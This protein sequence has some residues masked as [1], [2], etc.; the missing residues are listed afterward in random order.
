MMKLTTMIATATGIAA[1][2][3]AAFAQ[4]GSSGLPPT[5]SDFDACN[6][7]AQLIRGGSASPATSPQTGSS[8]GSSRTLPSSIATGPTG[9][10]PPG[11]AGSAAGATGGT[12]A[13]SGGSTLSGGSV[14]RDARVP[15]M[16]APVEADPALQQAYRDC[17]R[18]R[19]F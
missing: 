12:G 2:C 8:V 10:L 16:S 15:G 7:E 14:T 9:T 3:S 19:G 5:Q 17:L 6:R 4:T 11:G 18:R 13:L 1:L